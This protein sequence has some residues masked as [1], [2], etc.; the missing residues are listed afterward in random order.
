MA[1]KA[2]AIIKLQIPAG[3]ANPAPPVGPALGQHGINIMA[4]CKDY[5]E[6]TAAQ[7]GAIIPAEI[8]VDR[9]MFS[10]ING[11][12][13]GRND[14]YG[15]FDNII[16]HGESTIPP[17]PP[18]EQ[19]NVIQNGDFSNG[20]DAWSFE[21]VSWDHNCPVAPYAEAYTDA[22]RAVIHGYSCVSHGILDQSF[23]QATNPTKFSFD[24]E[25]VGNSFISQIS[26]GW[27]PKRA[28]LVLK[29]R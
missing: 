22:N 8:T 7:A 10:A 3:K 1:K 20:L 18:P 9:V 26:C 28:F 25:D 24:Y 21:D 16:L 6:R 23:D 13:D 2:I 17:D 15:Y 19:D 14:V 27:P 12:Y 4:F 29:E 5:N 11:C